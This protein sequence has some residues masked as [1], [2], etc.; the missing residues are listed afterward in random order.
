MNKEAIITIGSRRFSKDFQSVIPP[1]LPYRVFHISEESE[2]GIAKSPSVL[3]DETK[4]LVRIVGRY[5]H[6]VVSF[7]RNTVIG[8]VENI[9]TALDELRKL[10][11]YNTTKFIGPGVDT[12]YSFHDKW[13]STQI[14][15]RNGFSVLRTVKVTDQNLKD[16]EGMLIS[17]EFPSPALLKATNLTGGIGLR[18]VEEPSDLERQYAS[19]K[20]QGITESVLTEYL[21]GPEVSV[22]LLYLDDEI[23]VFPISIKDPT[24]KTLKHGDSKVKIC[25]YINPIPSILNEA[26]AIARKYNTTGYFAIEGIMY[27]LKER[28]WKIMEGMTRFTGSYPMLNATLPSFD[29]LRAVFYYINGQPWY[30]RSEYN[31]VVVIQV[32]VFKENLE[33]AEKM[34]QTLKEA[35]WIVQARV[36]NLA[37][38]PLSIDGRIR[39]QVTFK[40]G[41]GDELARRCEYLEDRLADT[42]VLP[43][44]KTSLARLDQYFPDLV[45]K[46]N[47]FNL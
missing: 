44:I 14:L 9:A 12:A 19:Q 20:E 27:D 30:P 46:N 1:E 32:P 28:K 24:E 26:V 47:L 3:V 16:I 37:D 40:A 13:I 18:L 22:E 33:E 43:R 21:I 17:G 29:S 23:L 42:T 11:E 4:K 25:G 15:E 8:S 5:P 35:D 6:A 45:Y 38:L 34:I 39:I 31:Q 2:N 36:D 7:G 10:S 41:E